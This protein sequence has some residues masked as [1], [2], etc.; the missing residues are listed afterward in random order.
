M[1]LHN[2]DGMAYGPDDQDAHPGNEDL[3]PPT[4]PT[5]RSDMGTCQ[6][7]HSAMADMHAAPEARSFAVV[8]SGR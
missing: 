7:R 4:G 1:L 8:T 3:E 5:S 6:L 2:H